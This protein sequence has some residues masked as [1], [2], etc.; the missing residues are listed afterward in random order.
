MPFEEA[1]EY[2]KSLKFMDQYEFH[3]F[4]EENKIE[5]IPKRPDYV[6]KEN[7][8]G[9]LDFL[10]CESNK[11]S[12]GER[13]IRTYLLENNILFEKEKRFKTCKNINELPFDF[14]LPEY[15]LCIEYDGELHYKSSAKYGGEKNLKRQIKHD[16]I[17]TNWCR[18]NSVRLLRISYLKK[19]KIFKILK[20]EIY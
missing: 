18:L 4:I 5:F 19:N 1:K 11:E 7:W 10:G 13:L 15:N 8:K 14:Y 12:I 2:I 16:K 3:R 17:K 9:Y 20:S 6:Y